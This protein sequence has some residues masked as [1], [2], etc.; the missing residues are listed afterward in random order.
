MKTAE[1]PGSTKS[2]HF[3]GVGF[4]A[5][6]I[7]LGLAAFFCWLATIMPNNV[8]GWIGAVGFGLWGSFIGGWTLLCTFRFWFEPS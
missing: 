1:Y 4:T 6:G 5:W 3:D 7:L 2:Y 8:G